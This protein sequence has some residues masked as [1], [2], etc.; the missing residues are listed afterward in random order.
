MNHNLCTTQECTLCMACVNTCPQEAIDLGTDTYGYEQI[1]IDA[2]KC[3]D[4]GLCGKV[5][6][7]RGQVPRSVP[8][9]NYAAQAK[10]RK[11]LMNSASGGAFQMLA[12]MVLEQGGVCYGCAFEKENGCFRA[13]HVRVDALTDLPKILNSKYIPSMIS[14][15]FREAKHDLETGS[16]VLFSGTPCQILGLKAFL[17][18]DYDNLLTA[19]L[20]CHGVTA[21]NLFNDYIAHL[22]HRDGIKIVDYVFRDKSVSWGT[23]YCYSYY[24]QGD[25]AKHIL[26]KHCPR[27]ASSYMIH[28]LRDNIFRENCY[29]CSLSCKERVS[30]FTLGDYWEIEQE[31]PEY[32]TKCKPRI[33]LRQGVSCI[34]VNSEKAQRFGEQLSQKMIMHPVSLD[35]ITTHNG[36]L[37]SASHRGKERDW[38]LDTY[39]KDGYAPIEEKYRR[40][41]GKKMMIYGIKNF[42]KS[43]MP[44]WL[45]IWIYQSPILR[46][47]VFH[48]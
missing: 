11:S 23:N 21:T 38:F 35:S 34:L 15:A 17:N 3:I 12:Q 2:E 31:H 25:P 27:E 16:L 4:C 22:E 42:L 41:V 19:D 13:K 9:I 45:R 1:T 8:K 40:S 33:V 47:I 44:D 20:I 28:Y 37:R 39:R 48:Q 7:R 36:N 18:R 14:H 46:R 5:C 29:S 10:D 32:I 43:Y 6:Q 26:Q 24:K 30:D